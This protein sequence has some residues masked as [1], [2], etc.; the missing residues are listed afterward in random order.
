MV[1]IFPKVLRLS[2]FGLGILKSEGAGWVLFKYGI[3]A[4]L[5]VRYQPVGDRYSGT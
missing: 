3:H 1:E 4:F 5:S 2:V